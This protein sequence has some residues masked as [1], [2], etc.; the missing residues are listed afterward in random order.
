MISTN[1]SIDVPELEAG[2]RFYCGVFGWKERSRPFPTM[3]VVDANNLTICIHEK[4]GGSRP[5]PG[6]HVR[7]YDRH[8]TPVHLD[9]HVDEFDAVLQR[10]KDAGAI[11]EMS[12]DHPKPTA[13][14]AD[15]FGH[16]FCLISC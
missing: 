3:A 1:I 10:A 6:Q 11:V 5:T 16:G 7:D 4:P 9:L 12:F 8:W 15:P 13:F 14:C 2:L